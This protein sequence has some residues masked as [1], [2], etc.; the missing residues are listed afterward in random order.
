MPRNPQSSIS[1]QPIERHIHLIRG[2]KVML[3][4][5]LAALY[6]VSTS[7]LNQA[8][9][10]NIERF[11]EDFAFHHSQEELANWRSQTV[12]SNPAAKMALRRPPYAFTQEGVAM[13]F[14][15]A[16]QR[17]RRADEHPHHA[18]LRPLARDDRGEQKPCG[19]HREAGGEPGGRPPR[20]S[21]CSWT[22]LTASPA[23]SKL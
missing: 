11:P 4:A 14:V 15:G 20:S 19:T 8:V 23:K 9:R 21:T 17:T 18:H 1:L 13:L 6:G 22:I 10:R 3:D 16:A 12:T 7:A 2:Q 5:D